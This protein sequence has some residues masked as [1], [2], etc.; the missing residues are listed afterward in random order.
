MRNPIFIIH[1][2]PKKVNAHLVPNRWIRQNCRKKMPI[3]R[4]L[5]EVVEI[6]KKMCYTYM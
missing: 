6:Q 4:K 3:S 1:N 5:R 2:S